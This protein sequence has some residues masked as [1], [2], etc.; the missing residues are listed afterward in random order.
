MRE[1]WLTFI[2][3][4]FVFLS[5]NLKFKIKIGHIKTTVLP[6]VLYRGEILLS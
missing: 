3:E 2:S 4:Y 6:I 1:C 5:S